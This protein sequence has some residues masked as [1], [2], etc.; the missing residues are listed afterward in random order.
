MTLHTQ[1]IE[2]EGKEFIMLP[3][4]EFALLKDTLEDYEDLKALREERASS[5]SEPTRSLDAVIKEVE[6]EH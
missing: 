3:A 5:G 4:D 6:Q 1:I 2:K